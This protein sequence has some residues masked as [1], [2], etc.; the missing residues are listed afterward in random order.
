MMAR[1][2]SA[3]I[4]LPIAC[5]S[6]ALAAIA[7]STA[8][9][10]VPVFYL[11]TQNAAST[12]G[13]VILTGTGPNSTGTVYL[14]ANSDVRLSGISLDLIETGGGIKFTG[15]EWLNPNNRWVINQTPVVTNSLVTSLGGG[16]IPGIA[17]GGIG[18]GA[19][20]TDAGPSVLLG[21]IS[22]MGVPG[23]DS[24]RLFLRVGGLTIADWQGNAPQVRFG[25]T[26]APLVPGGVPGGAGNVGA[27]CAC[28]IGDP[29]VVADVN[30]GD[31]VP[32]SI[33]DHT[34]TT[35]IGT[36]P[37]TWVGLIS[38]GP[39]APANP[40][41][42]TSG[43]AFNWNSTGSRL[44]QYNFDVTSANAG[45]S[46]VGRLT[47]NLVPEPAGIVLALVIVGWRSAIRPRRRTALKTAVSISRE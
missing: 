44:G 42:L 47:V 9:H 25:R 24:I 3:M 11:S 16:A 12:P 40:P 30:L 5:L 32:G 46:D 23:G 10:A 20:G 21:S 37:I 35:S 34:F 43:G 2:F 7:F 38:S 41:T 1:Q 45:G 27:V 26:T 18:P 6:T 14:W 29:P 13:D 28:I 19:P 15:A 8:A 36:P 22:Y 39:G 31:H 33:I 4:R 17:G